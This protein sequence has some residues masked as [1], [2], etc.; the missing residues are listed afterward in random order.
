ML[1]LAKAPTPC[2]VYG[3]PGRAVYLSMLLLV[4]AGGLAQWPLRLDVVPVREAT[5]AARNVESR[6]SA[7][8]ADAA[9]S[10]TAAAAATSIAAAAAAAQEAGRTRGE[11]DCSSSSSSSSLKSSR[12][13]GRRHWQQQQQHGANAAPLPATAPPDEAAGGRLAGCWWSEPLDSLALLLPMSACAACAV[14]SLTLARRSVLFYQSTVLISG[15][16]C[17]L[18]PVS[19]RLLRPVSSLGLALCFYAPVAYAA[20]PAGSW[21]SAL[22]MSLP[23]FALGYVWANEVQTMPASERGAVSGTRGAGG[24]NRAGRQRGGGKASGKGQQ[25]RKQS[26]QQPSAGGDGFWFLHAS[27]FSS[28]REGKA[29]P[30]GG[31][32]SSSGTPSSA[33]PLV[34]FGGLS[35][36]LD[37]VGDGSQVS[38]AELDSVGKSGLES[39]FS[40][41]TT[42]WEEVGEPAVARME[43]SWRDEGPVTVVAEEALAAL[44]THLPPSPPQPEQSHQQRRATSPP[45]RSPGMP[46]EPASS[47]SLSAAV[48]IMTTSTA[49]LETALLTSEGSA[50]ASGGGMDS[51]RECAVCMERERSH[52][53][54]PCGHI[55]LCG[56]CVRSL[57]QASEAQAEPLKCPMC[58]AVVEGTYKVWGNC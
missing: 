49:E 11:G 16:A 50:S 34:R 23:C 44:P 15:V 40:P 28:S 53:C 37:E 2:D 57:T 14:A 58:N 21:L 38:T 51:G 32:G 54:I 7:A 35:G 18:R 1:V 25:A 20:F 19:H 36:E 48:S 9:A 3:A 4:V 39:A 13:K 26:E 24:K 46:T 12:A 55:I 27:S 31:C 41:A 10:A 45:P 52:I 42:E 33:E 5:K 29:R 47:V 30:A 6:S 22:S 8:V 56:E 43:D 17:G